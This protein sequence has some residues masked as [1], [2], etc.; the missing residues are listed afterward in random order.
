M[1]AIKSSPECSASDNTPRLPVAAARNTLS[2]TRI[3]AEPIDPSAAICFADVGER[4]MEEPSKRLYDGC[5][6]A[7]ASRRLFAPMLKWGKLPAGR[8]RYENRRRVPHPC[9]PR[10]IRVGILTSVDSDLFG[11]PTNT[12]LLTWSCAQNK[13]PTLHKN[14]EGWGTQTFLIILINRRRWDERQALRLA[15]RA[16]DFH[17][18]EQ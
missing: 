2:P 1:A 15:A 6:V 8:R 16:V 11:E 17:I 13:I 12:S 5:V 4:V 3:K 9:P 7:P 10:G 14:S 18:I